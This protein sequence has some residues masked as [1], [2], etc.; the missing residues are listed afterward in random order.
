MACGLTG[1]RPDP[2]GSVSAGDDART[3]NAALE[4][5]AVGS[6]QE[7]QCTGA[8]VSISEGETYELAAW[9]KCVGV[10]GGYKVTIDWLGPGGHV[11]YSNDWAGEDGPAAYSLHGGRF[12]APE[13]ARAAAIILGVRPGS[14]YLFDDVSLTP[15]D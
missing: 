2:A 10:P 11:A 3:G 5:D 15:A 4:L 8:P 1:W 14:T 7:V 12:T 13:G 6:T 9:V